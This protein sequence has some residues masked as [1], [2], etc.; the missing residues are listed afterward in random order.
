MYWKD[1]SKNPVSIEVHK[2]LLEELRQKKIITNLDDLLK[3]FVDG[4]SVLDVGV[5]DHDM[6]HIQSDSW[7]HRKLKK[8]AK[9]I[10][11]VDILEEEVSILND[12]GFDVRL[13]DATSK[14]DLGEKFERVVI[15]DVIEH[16]SNPVALLEFAARHLSDDGQ[17]MVSTPNP[18]SIHF[19]LR[20]I[21]EG[22]FIANAEHISW[23]TPTMA[24]E[25]ANRA[26]I[27]LKNYYINQ[28]ES[29]AKRLIKKILKVVLRE[30][31][32]IYTGSYVYVFSK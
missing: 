31:N 17:I 2:F 10:V 24:L 9:K 26:G 13:V 25:I 20:V 15:G 6:S 30:D 29:L 4:Y 21:R 11:G 18:F 12:M 32:E 8:L 16:V 22:T 7:K 14:T 27:Y 1:I 28:P 5:V 19:I 3:K 23:I